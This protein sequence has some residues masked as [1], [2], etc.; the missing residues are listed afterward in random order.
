[1]P[2][3]KT[4]RFSHEDVATLLADHPF[5]RGSLGAKGGQKIVVTMDGEQWEARIYT[6]EPEF[7]LKRAE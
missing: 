7:S 6:T 4:L 5:T 3:P 1:M 2:H